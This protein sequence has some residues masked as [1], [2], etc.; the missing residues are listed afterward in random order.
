MLNW[1][2]D[3]SAV[4]QEVKQMHKDFYQSQLKFIF[5]EENNEIIQYH[6]TSPSGC[7]FD[8]LLIGSAVTTVGE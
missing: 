6:D 1:V 2:L 3:F 5:K 7:I 8:W 4:F